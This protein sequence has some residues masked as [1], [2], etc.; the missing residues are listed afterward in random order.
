MMAVTVELYTTP[1]DFR[2]NNLIPNT[3]LKEAGNLGGAMWQSGLKSC[4]NIANG[5]ETCNAAA[6]YYTHCQKTVS[7][8][9]LLPWI[10]KDTLRHLRFF[11]LA[12]DDEGG[13]EAWR[14]AFPG[15]VSCRISL[16]CLAMPSN[17]CKCIFSLSLCSTEKLSFSLPSCTIFSLSLSHPTSLSSFILS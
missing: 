5:Y 12:L 4:Q 9:Q 17:S 2:T 3:A 15:S 16:S 10:P 1:E 14:T 11:E 8:C 13:K 6:T 7:D